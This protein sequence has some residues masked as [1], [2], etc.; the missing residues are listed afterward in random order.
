ME[1]HLL[2]TFNTISKRWQYNKLPPRREPPSHPNGN[3]KKGF[4]SIRER[5]QHYVLYVFIFQRNCAVSF[6]DHGHYD[7]CVCM[8]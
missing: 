8:R 5:E 7:V 2:V 1:F 3:A 4:F 6:M